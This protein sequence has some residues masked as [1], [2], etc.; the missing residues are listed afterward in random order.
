M[1]GVDLADEVSQ[2][3]SKNAARRYEVRNGSA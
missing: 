2:K 3:L 1:V